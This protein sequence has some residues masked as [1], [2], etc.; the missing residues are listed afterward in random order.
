MTWILRATIAVLLLLLGEFTEFAVAGDAP[1]ALPELLALAKPPSGEDLPLEGDRRLRALR[2]AARSWGAQAGLARRGWEIRRMAEGQAGR[3]SAVW[4][5]DTLAEHVA[6]FALLPPQAAESGPALQV[7]GD[8][9]SAVSAVRVFRITRPARLVLAV[10]TWRDWLLRDWASPEPP[11]GALWPR[12]D[13]EREAWRSS[14]AA[15]WGEGSALAEA[16]FLEDLARLEAAWEGMIVWRRLRLQGIATA[17]DVR[18][19]G[20]P[21]VGGGEQMLLEERRADLDGDSGLDPSW[22][23]WVPAATE[24][25]ERP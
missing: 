14:L 23:E 3:L 8:G 12:S 2:L 4:R 9:R 25:G 13:V 20:R 19:S 10:P 18:T 1:P 5:F 17:Q 7:S 21:V 16:A 15:G 6:G 11:A 22:T 24:A